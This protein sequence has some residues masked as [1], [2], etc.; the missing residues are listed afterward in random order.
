VYVVISAQPPLGEAVLRTVAP[1]EIDPLSI[2]TIVGGTVGGYITFAGAHRL[3]D[4]GIHGRESLGQVTRS[5]TLGIGVASLMRILLFLATLGVVA[6][7]ATLDPANPPASAFEHAAGDVGQRIFGI[8][9]WAAAITSVVGSA[10][11]SVS[12]LRSVSR[13]V[14]RAPGR[15]IIAFIAISA[16]IF[17]A[18]GR[19]VTV[20]VLVGAIN[21]LILPLSLGAMLIAAYRTRIV[22]TYRHPVWLTIAGVIVAVAMAA[23]GARAVLSVDL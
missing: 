3:I 18:I 23:L 16:V 19:P 17:L 12:F 9:M 4:A 6:R 7:G 13:H 10:Y 14:D 11:T 8:V 2:V 5:A 15:A 1:L 21:G 22:G 20:L